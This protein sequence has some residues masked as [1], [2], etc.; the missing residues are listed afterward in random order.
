MKYFVIGFSK[1]DM[2]VYGDGWF[3]ASQAEHFANVLQSQLENT[4]IHVIPFHESGII[5]G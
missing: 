4:K 3:S 1:G 2:K 5:P